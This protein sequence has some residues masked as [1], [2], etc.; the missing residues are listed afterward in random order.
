MARV[1]DPWV[2]RFLLAH[3]GDR[4]PAVV[5]AVIDGMTARHALAAHDRVLALAG[6]RS[7]YVRGAV[8]RYL[9]ALFPDEARTLLLAGLQDRHFVVRES[10]IDALDEIEA[11][12]A[13]DAIRPMLND[14]RPHVR[15]AAEWAVQHLRA[16]LENSQCRARADASLGRQATIFIPSAAAQRHLGLFGNV[17]S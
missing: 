5:M 14:P 11:V 10:A 6:H 1:D 4:R 16:S 2:E 7:P 9:G 8:L 15:Q 17:G 3:L 13:V 12:D